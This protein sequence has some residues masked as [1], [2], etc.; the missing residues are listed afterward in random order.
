MRSKRCAGSGTEG[1]RRPRTVTGLPS[2]F[3]AKTDHSCF[4]Y[5]TEGAE[6][7]P[8]SGPASKE[9]CDGGPIAADIL[10]CLR[11]LE[12]PYRFYHYATLENIKARMHPGMTLEQS[13]RDHQKLWSEHFWATNDSYRALDRARSPA[14]QDYGERLFRV[15]IP[16]GTRVMEA[17]KLAACHFSPESLRRLSVQGAPDPPDSSTAAPQ[18][19]AHPFCSTLSTRLS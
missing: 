4:Q 14:S 10:P 17:N 18:E 5:T 12:R 19:L 3:E 8:A 13:I 16:A 9:E 7:R 11:T 2:Y 6:I 1:E 15:E